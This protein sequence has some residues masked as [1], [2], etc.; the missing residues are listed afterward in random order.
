MRRKDRETDREFAL[1]VVDKCDYA[2][3][4]MVTAE[5]EPYCIPIS[6]V[7]KDN[8]IYFHCAPTGK[9]IDC[10]KACN[11]VCLTCVGDTFKPPDIFTTEFESAVVYGIADEVTDEREKVEALRLLCIRHTP[12]NMAEFDRAIE[13]SLPRTAVYKIAISVITGKR[14]KYGKDGKELKFIKKE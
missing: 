3:L 14:K 11:K 9:K 13:T 8:L 6:I 10:L 12:A 5:G 1:F 4:S 2:V 7:R